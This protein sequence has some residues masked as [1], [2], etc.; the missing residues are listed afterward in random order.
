MPVNMLSFN[1]LNEPG[2]NGGDI[3]PDD[4]YGKVMIPAIDAIR[5]VTPD[6]LIFVDVLGG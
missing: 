3:V 6:R 4:L 1:L 2:M 5:A